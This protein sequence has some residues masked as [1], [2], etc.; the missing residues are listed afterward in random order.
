M[1]DA[2]ESTL[3]LA[4]SPKR[5]EPY[6]QEAQQHPNVSAADLYRWNSL[7]SG[8]AVTQISF[9]EMSVR[10]AID[11][12]LLAWAD[13]EGYTDWLGETPPNVWFDS[14][15]QT[16]VQ[17]IPPLIEALI[18]SG[19]IRQLW[20]CCR[21]IYQSWKKDPSHPKHGT[22]PNRD[23]AFAQLMFGSWQALLGPTDF[24]S[25]DPHVNKMATAARTLW[26]APCDT[27]SRN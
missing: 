21:K 26:K 3:A 6:E 5:L 14:E 16:P 19:Q 15:D 27:L 25:K 24:N 22:Y 12:A 17:G 1:Q 2:T 11:K 7:F 10:N 8:I 23:D 20:S 9:V 13:V 4:I 18:G